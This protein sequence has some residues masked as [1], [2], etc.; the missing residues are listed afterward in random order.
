M[1]MVFYVTII[2]VREGVP[3]TSFYCA[4]DANSWMVGPSG[5]MSAYA[6]GATMTTE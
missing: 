2:M 4:T 3:S 5:R 1:M 6:D